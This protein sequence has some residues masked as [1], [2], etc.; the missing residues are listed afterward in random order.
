MLSFSVFSHQL[1]LS[2][3]GKVER[4]L[5]TEEASLA[6]EEASVGAQQEEGRMDE[7]NQASQN[8]ESCWLRPPHC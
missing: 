5:D 1:F 4:W 7:S 3:V 2:S 8:H 6:S